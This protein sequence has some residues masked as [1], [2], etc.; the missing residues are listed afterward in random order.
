MPNPNVY[1]LLFGPY[2]PPRCRLGR[3]L[4]CE[5]RGEVIVCGMTDARIP[6]PVGKRGRARSLSSAADWPGPSGGRA[7]PAAPSRR[8]FEQHAREC[9]TIWR[10]RQAAAMQAIMCAFAVEA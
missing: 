6:W 5:V 2:R 3:I 4:K 8:P 10:V 9:S 1:R 7:L